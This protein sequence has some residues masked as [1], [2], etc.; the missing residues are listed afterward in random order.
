MGLIWHSDGRP[1]SPA[2]RVTRVTIVERATG[3]GA[4]TTRL[5]TIQPGVTTPPHWHRVEEAMMVLE[6][7][8]KAV[9][10]DEVMD[11]RAGATLLGP[12]AFRT[13]PSTPARSRCCSRSPS[14]QSRS[15][16][17]RPD[18]TRRTVSHVSRLP[19]QVR[20]TRP[21]WD[22]VRMGRWRSSDRSGPASTCSPTTIRA[23]SITSRSTARRGNP[24]R[25]PGSDSATAAARS[26]SRRQVTMVAHV[27]NVR[28]PAS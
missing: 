18:Q 16:P 8:G 28:C 5:V 23:R 14:R 26:C 15:R 11:I 22:G 17:S 19:M 2:P 12:A 24:G 7:E 1:D 27:T 9:L 6:G 21:S 13:A 3:A 10:G 25:R 20:E 4:L